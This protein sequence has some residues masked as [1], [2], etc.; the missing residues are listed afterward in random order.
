[1]VHDAYVTNETTEWIVTPAGLHGPSE[2]DIPANAT[3]AVATN[4]DRN[5]VNDGIFAKHLENTHHL[6][7]PTRK[8]CRTSRTK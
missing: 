2:E 8:T 3:Y 6:E 4:I 5:A 1:M 7:K